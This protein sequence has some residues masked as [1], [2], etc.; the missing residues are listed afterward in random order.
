MTIVSAAHPYKNAKIYRINSFLV[1]RV[2]S[3][4]TISFERLTFDTKS[5]YS[6]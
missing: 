1:I 3:Y 6:E 4:A 5:E 2:L